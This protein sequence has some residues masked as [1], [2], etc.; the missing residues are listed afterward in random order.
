MTRKLSL[1]LM[2]FETVT[3]TL[4]T[5]ARSGASSAL[6]LINGLPVP[7]C[8]GYTVSLPSR[9]VLTLTLVLEGEPNDLLTVVQSFGGLIRVDW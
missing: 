4:I 1:T 6:V 7:D 5:D 9:G 3:C 2:K 8:V